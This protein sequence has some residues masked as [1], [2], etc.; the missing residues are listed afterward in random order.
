MQF[1]ASNGSTI[2]ITMMSRRLLRCPP[3]K[4]VSLPHSIPLDATG[5]PMAIWF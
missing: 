2:A 5:L 3:E 4:V 1:A